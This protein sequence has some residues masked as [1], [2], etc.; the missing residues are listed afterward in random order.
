MAI[1]RTNL[2]AGLCDANAMKVTQSHQTSEGNED[3]YFCTLPRATAESV[4]YEAKAV[5]KNIF[6]WYLIPAPGEKNKSWGPD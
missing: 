6:L 1:K 4:T 3:T 5:P 2:Q